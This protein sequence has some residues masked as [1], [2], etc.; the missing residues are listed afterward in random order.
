MQQQDA[1]AGCCQKLLCEL[2]VVIT[3]WKLRVGCSILEIE[4][5]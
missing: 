5:Y 1:G 3:I 2:S 4:M